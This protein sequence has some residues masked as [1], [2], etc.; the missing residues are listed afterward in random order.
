MTRPADM[1]FC[2]I[3][4]GTSNS[5]SAIE[6]DAGMRLV[7]LEGEHL[8][9]PTAVFYCTDA[10]DLPP[11]A[12]RG[13]GGDETLPRCVGRA[14]VQAYIDGYEGRLMRSMKSVLGIA[15]AG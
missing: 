2:A 6:A 8:P 11:A 7:P 3:D 9:M 1:N 5:A 14:A 15:L 12:M 4:F 13:P 10:D